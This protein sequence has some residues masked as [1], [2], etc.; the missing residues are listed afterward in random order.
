M[1]DTL[2]KI[3][4]ISLLPITGILII[5]LVF[6]LVLSLDWPW[7]VGIFLLF[8]LVGLVIG[9]LFLRKLWLKRR[10]QK[11]VQQIIEQ[12]EARLKTIKGSEKD[13][14]K[15]LQIRWK[16][17]VD[18]LRRSHLRKYGNPLYVLPWYLIMG[19][20]GSGKTTAIRSAR[21]SS[22]F[23]E[24]TRTSGISGTQNCDWWFF[25][26]AIIIDTAGR[27]AIPV[28]EGKDKEEWQK[29]LNLLVKYRKREPIHGLIVT[30]PAD[31]LLESTPEVLEEDGRNIRRRIDE[32]MRVLGVKFPVYV[33]VTKCDLIQG[34][35]KFCDSLPEQSTEQP[36]G[37]INQDLSTDVTAFIN[38]AFN[39][40]SER[41]RN[42]RLLLLHKPESK[43][44]DPGLLLFPEEFENLKQG[45]ESFMKTA[46]QENPYQETPVLRGLFFSSGRQEGSPFSHFL[47]TLGLIGEKEVLPGTDRGLFL[48]DFFS[49][50]LPKDR[51]LFAPTRHALEWQSLTRNLGMVS[52]VVIWIAICG[53]LSFAFVKNLKTLRGASH[54]FVKPPV[55]EGEFMT[56][57][58]T[59]DRF[60]RAISKIEEQNRDWWIPRFGLNE[61]INVEKELKG[62]YC[63]QFGNEF[64]APIDKRMKETAL[65][66]FTAD[67][68]D[69]IAAQYIM[70]LVRRINLLNARLKGEDAEVIKTLPRPPFA[71]LLATVG[72][73]IEPE[74]RQR[75]GQLYLYYVM[76]R[77]DIG[78][79][80]KEIDIFQSWL[81]QLLQVKAP[82]PRWIAVWVNREGSVPPVTLGDFWGGKTAAE[83]EK[84]IP[85][86][87]CRQGKE[88]I[89]SLIKE[90]ETALPNPMIFVGQKKEFDK[91]YRNKSFQVWQA[92]SE[93]FPEGKGRL[94]T[95]EEWRRMAAKMSTTE[96]PYFAFI[97]R[98]TSDL[99]PLVENRN[100]PSW[101]HQIYQFNSIRK[102][103]SAG[104]G[105]IAKAA[106]K[107]KKVITTLEKK[108]R[109]DA[110][111]TSE[112]KLTAISAYRKYQ[113]ALNAISTV[114]ASGN[115]AYQMTLQAFTED[116]A[117]GESPFL[118]AYKAAVQLKT[119]ITEEKLSDLVWNLVL[120]PFD[121]IWEY[122]LR[123]T[124]CKLQNQWEEEVLAEVQG[125]SSDQA[126]ELLIGKNGYA[127][128][129]VK[130]SAQPF[131]KYRQGRGYHARKV[132]GRTVP[133][134]PSFFT[135]LK[136]GA[137]AHA[138]ALTRQSYKVLIEGLPTDAN[139]DARL[140]PHATHLELQCGSLI[141][142]LDNYH[143]PVSNNFIWSPQSCSDVIFKIEIGD[144][145]LTRHYRGPQAFVDFLEDFQRGYRTFKPWEFP[146]E[147]KALEDMGIKYIKANYKFRGARAVLKKFRSR[148]ERIVRRITEC[149]E[150]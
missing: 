45:I 102:I 117:T 48:H 122:A 89:D 49:K 83:D 46:F 100:A 33:L 97:E 73:D 125:A 101:L 23:V 93:A 44:V 58:M 104:K 99:E 79:V 70:Q 81:K 32:L 57:F 67:T 90:I 96:G 35:T 114:S 145:V 119:N 36:M 84:T 15:D 26:Q 87:Y 61:S 88:M 91:W 60:H 50:I 52:W 9:A 64:L 76:W 25:E 16:E 92:F 47:N 129:F 116:P 126:V 111:K 139:S 38:R 141:Q 68:P 71:P 95:K 110:G 2:L 37:V 132:F 150:Q 40:L 27:Y 51:G 123:E 148:P 86:A 147:R 115:Q 128:K 5:L 69:D 140:K 108:L 63:R 21:L 134:E 94:N 62:K 29:F 13:E 72:E 18:T 143:F 138:D 98:I 135:F 54:E 4:K 74:I 55:I 14:L 146:R 144:I 8:A 75:F 133:F 20:S 28:D 56:D 106:E 17:A 6:G 137:S 12:D 124:A 85:P 34:M 109:K 39:T 118:T 59:M 42:L 10:E 1:K 121:F 130:E 43:E 131:V 127:W 3:L 11:F 24:V 136:K 30:V 7:W 19:E 82:I 31:K 65:I 112:S 107:G 142:I 53:L 41:L 77:S 105:T 113:E 66:N 80:G 103:G 22:P 120:G 149:W 78:E